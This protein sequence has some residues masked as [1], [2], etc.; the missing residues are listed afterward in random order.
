MNWGPACVLRMCAPMVCLRAM[1]GRAGASSVSVWVGLI[2][3]CAC[4]QGGGVSFVGWE[5]GAVSMGGC[6]AGYGGEATACTLQGCTLR[7]QPT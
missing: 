4:F 2:M 3:Q 5:A 1:W 6:P 7:R